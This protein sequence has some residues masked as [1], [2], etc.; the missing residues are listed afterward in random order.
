[1]QRRIPTLGNKDYK[2]YFEKWNL[3]DRLRAWTF[4]FDKQFHHYAKEKFVL[5]FMTDL[6][7]LSTLQCMSSSGGWSPLVSKVRKVLVEEIPCTVL[8]MEFFD[9]LKEY[10]IVRESGHI[11]K[12]FDEFY[13]GITISDELRKMILLED[14]DNFECYND[15]ER[16]EFLFRL[17]THICIGGPI[18]QYEDGIEPYFNVVKSLYKDCISVQKNSGTKEIE[19]VSRVFKIKAQVRVI[20]NFIIIAMPH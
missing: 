8:S 14:S 17:F 15:D 5:D 9:R 11:C 7:V 1:M 12:C 2:T 4:S 6:T 10:N 16:A 13:E 19:V 3:L 18:C 20:L